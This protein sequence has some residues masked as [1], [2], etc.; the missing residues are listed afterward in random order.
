MVLKYLLNICPKHMVDKQDVLGQT[1]LHYTVWNKRAPEAI[2]LLISRGADPW[3]RGINQQLILHRAVF[4][5]NVSAV[6]T[7][8]RLGLS[9]QLLTTDEDGYTPAGLSR[10]LASRLGEADHCCLHDL[11]E[12]EADLRERIASNRVMTSQASLNSTIPSVLEVVIAAWKEQTD[13]N[14]PR[15][16]FWSVVIIGS[17]II[18][19]FGK[20][21]LNLTQYNGLRG[22][23]LA[24]L[25]E[26]ISL[27]EHCCKGGRD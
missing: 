19:L 26:S 17:T 5:R 4:A 18:L 10:S 1:A 3:S 24:I 16:S 23:C 22:H 12:A 15:L 8:L 11:E 6:R 27:Q 21:L 2:E 14:S 7:L 20:T 25:H 13:A 9:Y